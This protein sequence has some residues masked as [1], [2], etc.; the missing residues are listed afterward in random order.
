MRY[1][2]NSHL[3]TLKLR[4]HALPAFADA[5]AVLGID[6]VRPREAMSSLE[7]VGNAGPDRDRGHV[8]DAGGDDDL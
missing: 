8:L 3:C 4:K 6:R 5:L 7:A 2:S 1:N